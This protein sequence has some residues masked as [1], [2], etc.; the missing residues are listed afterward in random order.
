MMRRLGSAPQRLADG[1]ADVLSAETVRAS[2]KGGHD[3]FYSSA[4][5]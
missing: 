2:Q 4:R 5:P 1:S 3:R